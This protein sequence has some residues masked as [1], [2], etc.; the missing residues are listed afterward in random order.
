VSSAAAYEH[1]SLLR[2]GRAQALLGR[3]G[4]LGADGMPRTGAGIIVAVALW[5]PVA[6]IAAAHESAL[7]LR[8]GGSFFVDIPTYA[9]LLVAP[10]ILIGME[11]V[12][13]LR[14]SR[15]LGSFE[16][17]GIVTGESVS[18]FRELVEIAHRRTGSRAAEAAM[19]AGAVAMSVFATLRRAELGA[20][21]WLEADAAAGGP[22]SP[23]GWWFA[24]VSLPVAFFLVL[25]W[26]WRASVLTALLRRTVQ[27]PLALVPT[28]PD[29]AGGLGFVTVFPT[30]CVPVALALSLIVASAV[31]QQVVFAGGTFEDV[32]ALG[33]A[34]LAMALLIFVGPLALFS[35]VLFRLRERYLVEYSEIVTHFNRD[36]ERSFA[37]ADAR[38]EQLD[39]ATISALADIGGGW[40]AIAGM[41]LIPV[42]LR[43]LVPLVLVALIPMFAVAATLVPVTDLL[44]RVVDLLR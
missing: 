9:R 21:S 39:A 2:G 22:L 35:P 8:F 10:A 31:M 11:R 26:L 27:L 30:I 38:R 17:S 23:A 5:L 40:A 33:F 42:D 44:K 14:L 19:L 20:G 32:R 37:E 36:A 41:R 13:D 6:A 7:D 1:P 25:R 29:R 34:W 28:H 4:L 3:L 24:L 43:T 12:A 18:R 16:R 15:L